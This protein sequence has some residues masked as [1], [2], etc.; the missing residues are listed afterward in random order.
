MCCDAHVGRTDADLDEAARDV[1][2]RNDRGGHTIPCAG[3]YPF[4]W[5]WDSAFAAWGWSTFDVD[6]AWTELEVLFTGQWPSGMLPHIVFHQA[7]RGYFPGPGVWATGHEPPTSGI[8]QPPVLATLVREVV[9]ADP[10]LAAERLPTLYPRLLAMHRWWHAVRCG[11]TGAAITHPWE[12]GRDNAA[13]WDRALVGVDASGIESY[14]RRDTGHVDAS[15]RPRR[16]DY[17]RYVALVE[18]GRRVA[19]DDAVV[20]ERSPFLVADPAI[21]FLLIRA[22]RDLAALAAMIGEDP[23]GPFRWAEELSKSA[24]RL[25]NEQLGA[26]DSLDL[27]S[28]SRG[29]SATASMWFEYLAGLGT[30]QT[31]RRLGEMWGAVAWGVPTHDPADPA[32]EPQRY[33]RGPVW[34]VVNA[35]IGRGLLDSGR[36]EASERLRSQTAALIR[37]GGFAEYFDPTDA[38]PCGGRDFTWTAAVWL[39]W[40]SSN[41]AGYRAAA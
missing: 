34:P 16:A 13:A 37:S 28:G 12:S 35:L 31:D 40:A 7:D 30:E 9:A 8:T 19:W 2:R 23:S 10:V 27:R 17:D 18:F 29:G 39:A 20:V 41:A 11:E 3:L 14:E 32:F 38:T 26:Y 15:M 6:R 36:H 4:Q 1:L 5:H 22:H 25:W 21:T 24:A 33:W